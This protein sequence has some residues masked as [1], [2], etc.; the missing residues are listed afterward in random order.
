MKREPSDY[1]YIRAWHALTGSREYYIIGMQERAVR[2]DAPLDA[3]YKAGEWVTLRD[4][5]PDHDMRG[6][7]AKYIG[8]TK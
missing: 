7:M 5:A 2:E 4:L 6:R 3:L 8:D 1:I